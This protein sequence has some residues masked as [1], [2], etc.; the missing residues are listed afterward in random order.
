MSIANAENVEIDLNESVALVFNEINKDKEQQREIEDRLVEKNIPRGTFAELLVNPDKIN[1]LEKDELVFLLVTVYQVTNDERIRPTHFFSEKD[2]NKTK[3]YKRAAE[4]TFSYPYTFENTVLGTPDGKEFVTIMTYK[5]VADIWNN[6]LLTYNY[7]TQRLSKKKVTAKGKL[8]EKAD[9]NIKSVK[10][11]TRLMLERKYKADTLLF[12]ILVN[13]NDNIDYDNGELTIHEGTSVNLIDGMHRVQAILSVLEEEPDY[14]GFINVAIKHY[15]LQEAQFML[16]QVNTVNRFDKTLIKNY[17]AESHGAQIAKDL[18][19]IPELRSRISIKTT[20]DKKLSYLT[21][22]AILSEA[23]DSIFDPQNTKER[24]DATEVLKKFFGYL[25]PAYDQAFNSKTQKEFS[26]DS[27]LN[28][29]N[30]FVGFV[31]IAKAL[32]DK[33]GFDYPTN[34]IVRIIDNINLSKEGSEFNELM[35]TQGKVNSNQVKKSIRKFFED[36]TSEILS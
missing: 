18:M 34:E 17:M 14:V 35:T 19:N 1:T 16:G 12:N 26:K 3:K 25:I 36:K 21:N 7:Q 29:H 13:G 27:W 30:T 2:I 23:I 24:Y 6:K 32:Y 5:E 8:T 15:P 22:F 28:H 9:V 10:N 4:S 31:V 11:I 33:F 20:L